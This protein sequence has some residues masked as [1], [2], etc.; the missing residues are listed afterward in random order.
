MQYKHIKTSSLLNKIT[1]RDKLFIGDYTLDPYQN[2]E[3]GCLYCDSS[4]DKN[5]YIKSNAV[6]L[7][8][9]ELK[10]IGKNNVIIVG[11]VHDPYQKIEEKYQLT[12]KLLR[13]IE[14]RGLSCHILTK[15]NLVNRDIDIISKI[16]NCIVTVSMISLEDS[17]S[18]FFEKNIPSSIERMETIEK[19]S[20][21][22]VKSGLALIPVLP[23]IVEREFENIVKSANAHKAHHLLYRHLELKGDQKNIFIDKLR[24]FKPTLVEKYGKLYK[25]SYMPNADYIDETRKTLGKLCSNYNLK[26]KIEWT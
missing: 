23:H 8:E 5:I 16:N 17:I 7:L 2:C 1:R 3:F 9:K 22:G 20:D 26:N 11:S 15:S 13:I 25:D 14:E 24:E 21:I 4:F 10:N 19:L 6:E 18:K 12:R